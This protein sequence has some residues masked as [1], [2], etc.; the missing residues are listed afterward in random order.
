LGVRR[1]VRPPGGA[2]PASHVVVPHPRQ[3]NVHVGS[4]RLPWSPRPERAS[5]QQ[6]DGPAGRGR[7]RSQPR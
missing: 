3:R 2:A 4:R 5:R 7:P 6:L 1:H